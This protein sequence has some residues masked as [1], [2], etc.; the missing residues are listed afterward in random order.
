M[1]HGFKVDA[2]V[3][4]AAI[5]LHAESERGIARAVGVGGRDEHEPACANI[6]RRHELSS[7]DVNTVVLQGARNR[8]R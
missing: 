5:V 8:Q 7:V 4:H 3:R 6:G 2:A 1:R